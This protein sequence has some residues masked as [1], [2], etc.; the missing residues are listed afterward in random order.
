MEKKRIFTVGMVS[1][2]VIGGFLGILTPFGFEMVKAEHTLDANTVAL[3]HFDEGSGTTVSDGGGNDNDGTIHGAT[4]TTGI[5]GSALSY[6]GVNDYV[7]VPYS[8]TFYPQNISIELWVNIHGIQNSVSSYGSYY[9]VIISTSTRG[10]GS[11]SFY[12]NENRIIDFN[13]YDVSSYSTITTSPL[14]FNRWYYLV[15]TYDGSTM[16]LYLNGSLIGTKDRTYPIVDTGNNLMIGNADH[17]FANGTSLDSPFLGVIDEIRIWNA[18]LNAQ[19]IAEYYNSITPFENQPPTAS[20]SVDKTSGVIPLEV[21]FTGSGTDTDRTIESYYWHFDDGET[22][23]EQNPTHTFQNSGTYIVTLMVT[24]DKDAVGT[25]TIT[26]VVSE[27][28]DL[29][30]VNKYAPILY[31]DDKEKYFPVDIFGDDFNVLNNHENY[32]NGTL[33]KNTTDGKYVCYYHVTEYSNF[34]VYQYWYY[35]AFNPFGKLDDH[36]HDFE[37]AFVWV[38][39]NSENP[40]Y[41]ALSQ[42]LWINEYTITSKNDLVA[43]VE[44]GGHGMARDAWMVI[45][46]GDDKVLNTDDFNFVPMS[47]LQSYE[48][49]TLFLTDD[50]D[51][52]T[53]EFSFIHIKAPWQRPRYSDPELVIRES[54]AGIKKGWLM[55]S[56]HSPGELRVCDSTGK[57]TGMVNGEIKY[58]IPNSGYSD[59]TV[60]I[61][62]PSDTYKYEI[63]GI[64]EGTYF[65]SI[66]RVTDKNITFEAQDIPISSGETHQYSIDWKALE[67]G[68]EG[69]T[70]KLDTDGDGTYEY[71]T[72][73]DVDFTIKDYTDATSNGKD[74]LEKSKEG[75][76]G[77]GKIVGVDVFFLFIFI[78]VILS[79][80]LIIIVVLI[81]KKR[82][83]QHLASNQQEQPQLLPDSPITLQQQP[84]QH[85]KSDYE[86][87]Y[88]KMPQ[89]SSQFHGTIK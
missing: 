1:L 74:E 84:H 68:E 42:H 75:L 88:G 11:Y 80:F 25:T 44:L 50:G 63:E 35:Y 38:D 28:I 8:S 31:F 29:V 12:L 59:E 16:S 39:K 83:R 76:F 72:T 13:I 40:F 5:S 73:V 51:F 36:E 48:T 32:D 45:G 27:H 10:T 14:S 62:Y 47:V 79:V 85:L 24:D 21:S 46:D 66:N 49:E 34:Y 23:N 61:L 9:T 19:E 52:K 18:S 67:G 30:D 4:W 53:D 43:F 33:P 37:A 64:S 3:W 54:E 56:I 55:A 86:R 69:A 58:E 65:L 77:F 70:I 57:V 7:E 15:G 20:I 89:S 71:T 78:T 22:S 6:D 41:Y 87:L 17:S 60:V 2:L 82:R 81:K 26:I